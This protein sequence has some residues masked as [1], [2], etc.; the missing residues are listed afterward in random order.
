[1]F[2]YCFI[3]HWVTELSSRL[4]L[5][6]YRLKT[7]YLTG[8]SRYSLRRELS[9]TSILNNRNISITTINSVGNSLK[10]A[11][12]KSHIIFTIGQITISCFLGTKVIVSV[13]ILYCIL[14]GIESWFSRVR[15]YIRCSLVG[16]SRVINNWGRSRFVYNR[17]RSRF[18]DN[19]SRFIDNWSR[20]VNNWSWPIRGRIVQ[21]VYKWCRGRGYNSVSDRSSSR[22]RCGGR[23]NCGGGSSC[24]GRS[25][26][27]GGSNSCCKC[28]IWS[29][30]CRFNI[31]SCCS[32]G[33]TS[34]ITVIRLSLSSKRSKPRHK[35]FSNCL[36]E[37]SSSEYRYTVTGL[38]ELKQNGKVVILL[39]SSSGNSYQ[40]GET[41]ELG[42]HVELYTVLRLLPC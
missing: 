40:D 4:E 30:S 15:I 3:L 21:M 38:A 36:L 13:V 37:S 17:G 25:S 9:L 18:V 28:N 6:L 22:G 12:R 32:R 1:M 16:R 33:V 10:S 5:K 29:Y 35:S 8:V 26:S 42:T 7:E 34:T 41:H 31:R 14:I 2:D 24:G 19:R 27:C 39:G 20:S 23:C 11:I